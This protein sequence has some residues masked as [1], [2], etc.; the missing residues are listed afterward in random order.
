MTAETVLTNARI[1]LADEIVEGSLLLRDGAIAAI[2]S[3]PLASSGCTSIRSVAGSKPWKR[4]C[5]STAWRSVGK[6]PAS[7]RIAGRSRVGR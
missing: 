6:A 7:I 2:D 3:V 1:V 4:I 5:A